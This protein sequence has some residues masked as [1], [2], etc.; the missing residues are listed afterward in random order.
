ML[1]EY[2][3]TLENVHHQ[4]LH[5]KKQFPNQYKQYNHDFLCLFIR[6]H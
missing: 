4:F 3:I 5:E 2:F 6:K 1:K